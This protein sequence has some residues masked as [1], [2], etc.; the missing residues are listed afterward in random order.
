MIPVVI[1]TGFLGTGKTSFLDVFLR[2]VKSNGNI[3]PALIVNEVGNVDI[4]GELL[5]GLDIEQISL[6]GGCVCCTLAT[7][8]TENMWKII[9]EKKYNMIIIEC[10]GLSNP[11]DVVSAISAP[12]M[13]KEIYLS[14]IICMF[15]AGFA[16]NVLSKSPIG[17]L[18]LDA[19]DKVIINKIDKTSKNELN[20][21]SAEI[22][23]L[24]DT[25]QIFHAEYGKIIE[26]SGEEFLK[27]LGQ[28]SG[29]LNEENKEAFVYINSFCTET[30]PL[31]SSKYNKEN[32]IKAL[33]NMPENVIRAKGFVKC[34]DEKWYSVQ[35]SFDLIDLKEYNY[36][37][38]S[39]GSLLVFIGPRIWGKKIREILDKYCE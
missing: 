18:Q 4:D 24:N 30:V 14:S 16:K 34:N 31:E 38:P 22:R 3:K 37:T 26:M 13:L 8:L 17:K 6:M 32:I 10:S 36:A 21:I 39:M 27:N 25:C 1:V 23:N 19:S 15:D 29:N 12:S 2:D 5:K 28:F 20:E 7:N 11:I 35:K 9:D 33:K